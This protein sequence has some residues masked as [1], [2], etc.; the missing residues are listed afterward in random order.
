MVCCKAV[1]PGQGLLQPG[2]A[3]RSGG[4]GAGWSGGEAAI[5]SGV[6]GAGW[7][8]GEAVIRSGG[9]GSNWSG[10]VGGGRRSG[11]H[12]GNHVLLARDVPDVAGV[13]RYVG[14]GAALPLHP[15]VSSPGQGERDGLVVGEYREL[16]SIKHV[17]EV[18]D[19]SCA[20]QQF[21]VKG[22]V[23]LLGG[24]ELL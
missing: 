11:H 23:S 1:Q 5:R 22:R 9:V 4:V 20:G 2:T 24:I 13:F 15:G 12:V 3:I 16:T 17:A 21:P 10:G 7:S 19:P 14:K 6:V 8:G 18:P